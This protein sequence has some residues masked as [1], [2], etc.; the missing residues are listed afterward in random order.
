MEIA[1][2]SKQTLSTNSLMKCM[3][4]RM[5]NLYLDIWDLKG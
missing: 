1:L 3:E 5:E 4:I 2:I